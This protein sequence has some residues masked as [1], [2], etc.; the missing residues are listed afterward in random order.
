MAEYSPRIQ[1]IGANLH[2]TV[3]IGSRAQAYAMFNFYETKTSNIGTPESFEGQTAAGG[4]Q[5]TLSPLLLPVFVCPRGTTAACTAAN[6]TLNPQNPF[7]AQGQQAELSGLFSQ[8]TE[9]DTDARTFRYSAGINGSFGDGWNYNFDATHSEVDLAVT[10]RNYI[11]AQHLLDVIADG[12]YNFG[13]PSANS[14]AESQYLSPTVTTNSKSLM[15]QVQGTL[16][17]SFYELP[18]GPLQ[19]AVGAS[20]RRESVD[21][22][23]ANPANDINPFDR[24]YGINSVGVIGSRDVKSAFYEI[25]APVL[26]SAR[27]E[28]LRPVRRLFIGSEQLLAEVRGAILADQ[29]NQAPRHLHQGLHHSEL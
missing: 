9:V 14:A 2:A 28:D 1:R 7:A 22:P 17:H 26:S 4:I 15:T 25:D 13:N 21:N 24:Y 19:V 10:D 23:S 20:W 29:S 16:A 11:L 8:P 12:S 3:N 18:G 6:G 5:E 27:S